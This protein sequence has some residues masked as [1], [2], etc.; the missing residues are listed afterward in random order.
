MWFKKEPQN[1]KKVKKKK[2]ES[3]IKLDKHEGLTTWEPK[4]T[5]QGGL[6][7]NTS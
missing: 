2:K 4:V 7:V 5:T 6:S 3:H 1:F